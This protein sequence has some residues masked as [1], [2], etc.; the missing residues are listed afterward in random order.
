[1]V[2]QWLLDGFPVAFDGFPVAFGWFYSFFWMVFQFLLVVFQFE[3]YQYVHPTSTQNNTKTTVRKRTFG[4]T[5]GC[6]QEWS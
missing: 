1:M 4:A 6:F 2:F 3:R 5:E